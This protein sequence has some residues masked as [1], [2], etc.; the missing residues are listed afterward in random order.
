MAHGK[1]L[2]LA[3]IKPHP[4][5]VIPMRPTGAKG[6][7]KWIPACPPGAILKSGGTMYE[8]QTT[9]QLLRVSPPRPWRGKSERRQA[10][11][12]RREDREL[13]QRNLLT[14]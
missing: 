13:A 14:A 11:R 9:G 7:T 1:T 8:Y 4:R 2:E 5:Y 10:I 3:K 6:I 12:N